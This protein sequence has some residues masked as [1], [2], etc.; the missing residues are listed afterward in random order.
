VVRSTPQKQ[1]DDRCFPVRIW[2]YTPPNGFGLE[3]DLMYQW[4]DKRL[5]RGNYAWHGGGSEFG[6]DRV[7]VYFRHPLAAAEFA[8]A[9]PSIEVKTG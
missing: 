8:A 7:A 5:G 4:L 3:M 6:R 1:I 9:F 2:F